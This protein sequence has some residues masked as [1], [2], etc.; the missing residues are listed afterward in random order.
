MNKNKRDVK[1][2]Q[3]EKLAAEV[4]Q[5]EADIADLTEQLATQAS[6]LEAKTVADETAMRKKQNSANAQTISQT[7]ARV[8]AAQSAIKVLQDFYNADASLLQGQALTKHV[9][10]TW[11][12]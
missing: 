7:A 10:Q 6:N 12:H 4:A 8:E 11:H 2:Q 3:I 5:L 1:F 9:S